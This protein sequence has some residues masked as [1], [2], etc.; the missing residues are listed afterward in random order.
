MK[1]VIETFKIIIIILSLILNLTVKAQVE[2]RANPANYS[3][4]VMKA[5][6]YG[7]TA[8]SPHNTQSW[9]IDT[10]SS[11]E[12]MLYVKHLLPETDPPSRQIHMGAGC[13][14]ELVAIGMSFEGYEV[15][16]E[17][18]PLGDYEMK[19][20]SLASKPVA[21]I[22]LIENKSI[23]KDTLYDYI[24]QRGTNRKPYEGNLIT[25]TEFEKIKGL[26]GNTWSE[27]IFINEPQK[28]KPYLDIFSIAM[29][30]ETKTRG[31]NEET[32]RNFR[33]SEAER[34]EKKD[35]ISIPQMGYSGMI[36]K[37]AEKSLNN[38]DS[39]TWHSEKNFKA[40]MKGINK[41]IYS[42]KGIVMFKTTTNEKL[43]WVK[44]GRDYARFNIAIA[45]L[46]IVTHPYN[47]VIQ[48]YEE[49]SAPREEFNMLCNMKGEEK[50]QMIVRIGRAEESYKSWRKAP[51]DYI[52]AR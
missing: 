1:I 4:P 16:V 46:G 13:F 48:E 45:A 36:E 9:F 38:G 27:M 42:S 2:K 6:A 30:I 49:M 23:S 21:K 47:Q 37:I 19:P 8:P 25:N 12:M 40:T 26:I 34:A 33:F 44:S 28:M 35:G 31:T 7:L 15:E 41:G 18:F 5:I 29:E 11:T 51:E 17:Y 22:K 52:I 50:V 24:Y 39:A 32:R 10:I 43:D 3:S 14:I 20:Y